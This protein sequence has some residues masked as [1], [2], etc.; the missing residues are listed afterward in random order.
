[1]KKIKKGKISLTISIGLTAFILTMVMVTQFKTIEE[2]DITGIEVM[3]EAELRTELATWKS[4]Y[5]EATSKIEETEGKIEDYTVEIENNNNISELL[6]K[7]LDEANTY[8]GYTDVTG[9]GIIITLEDTESAEVSSDDLVTLVNELRLAGAEAI[10]INNQRIIASTDITN[11]SSVAIFVNTAKN[12]VRA[13]VSSPFVIKAIGNQK[14]LESS[15][16]IK[17]GFLDTMESEGKKI[18]YNLDDNVT[19]SKYEGNQEFKYATIAQ[20]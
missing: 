17:Y 1:M 6:Q 14:Y 13:K 10:S 15:I 19:I 3:R 18:S 5:D 2:T 8:A 16:T 20:E 12:L 9:E 4:K 7:E 11:V